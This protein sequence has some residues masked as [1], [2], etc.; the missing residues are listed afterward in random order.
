FGGW[1]FSLCSRERI[2]FCFVLFCFVLF[3][4]VLFCFVLF[5]F[6]LFCFVLFCL[7]FLFVLCLFFNLRFD[8]MNEKSEEK[9][10]KQNK[11]EKELPGTVG[12]PLNL[13][14]PGFEAR[15]DLA[16]GESDLLTRE[17]EVEL[18]DDAGDGVAKHREV[19]HRT[20]GDEEL[21]VKVESVS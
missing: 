11:K 8:S 2:L 16:F 12:L 7:L 9:K 1:T 21:G 4:F 14:K 5:C 19:D 6:V 15:I 20:L 13:L 3:C 10:T 18:G 17:G